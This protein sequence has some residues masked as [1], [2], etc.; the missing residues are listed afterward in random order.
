MISVKRVTQPALDAEKR[1]DQP[2]VEDD[3]ERLLARL[4][5]AH[6]LRVVP[7]FETAVEVVHVPP[8]HV[9]QALTALEQQHERVLDELATF[10]AL[11]TDVRI[12]YATPTPEPVPKQPKPRRKP[13]ITPEGRERLR[14]SG[15][16]VAEL[17]RQ[18]REANA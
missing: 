18:K 7:K 12:A 10:R 8:Q 2:A 1:R 4:A 3:P 14:E 15:R 13:N 5:D 9:E 17:N 11:L 6:G 16:R